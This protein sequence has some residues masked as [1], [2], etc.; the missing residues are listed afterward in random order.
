MPI[1]LKAIPH[2]PLFLARHPEI[3]VARVKVAQQAYLESL[4]KELQEYPPKPKKQRITTGKPLTIA[5]ELAGAEGGVRVSRRGRYRRTKK[6]Q[7]GWKI[8]P[9][10]VGVSFLYNDTPYSVYVQ[11]PR[12]GGRG[13]GKRQT[14]RNRAVGWKSVSDV[15][16]ARV[17]EY[18][19]L[20]NRAIEGRPGR[21]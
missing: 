20:M 5:Q 18:P 2:T 12:G 1:A 15:A 3:I 21:I 19:Q 16:R 9:Q 4:K 6:L 13:I 7:K 10:G 17:K 8:L 11:G 14:A